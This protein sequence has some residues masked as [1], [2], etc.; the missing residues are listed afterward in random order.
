M[1]IFALNPW[2][3]DSSLW[4]LGP[5][6]VLIDQTTLAMGPRLSYYSLWLSAL[7]Y[8]VGPAWHTIDVHMLSEINSPLKSFPVNQIPI[9]SYFWRFLFLYQTGYF[10]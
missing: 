5:L 7:L 2:V 3:T 1:L 6:D 4:D 9:S 8:Q 10:G